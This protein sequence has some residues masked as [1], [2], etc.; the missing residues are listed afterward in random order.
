MRRKEPNTPNLGARIRA[1]FYFCA[2]I[3]RSLEAQAAVAVSTIVPDR[4]ADAAVQAADAEEIA[5][6]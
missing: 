5:E 6:G 2:E 4:R 1:P 3:Q